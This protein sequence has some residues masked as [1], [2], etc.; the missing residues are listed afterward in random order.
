[1]KNILVTAAIIIEN[2]RCLLAQRRS[3]GNLPDKWEFP[4]GKIEEGETPEQALRRE[5]AEELGLAIEVGDIAAVI[6]HQ[7]K[8]RNLI[9]LFYYCVK[10][11]G[12][13]QTLECQDFRWV[14]PVEMLA[15]DLAPA[16]REMAKKLTTKK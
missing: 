10:M 13:P 1:M 16:D 9:I 3:V 12:M 8:D 11:E 4:G 5:I 2:G 15:L 14:M 6:S 7:E